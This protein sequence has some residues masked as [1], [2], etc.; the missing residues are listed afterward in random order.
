ME[1]AAPS[2]EVAALGAVGFTELGPLV[3]VLDF[4]RAR[5]RGAH[6]AHGDRRASESLGAELHFDLVDAGL[7]DLAVAVF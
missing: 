7:Q 2:G 1:N 4:Q 5:D 3:D 6:A